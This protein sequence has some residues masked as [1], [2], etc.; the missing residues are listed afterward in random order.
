MSWLT[1]VSAGSPSSKRNLIKEESDDRAVCKVTHSSEVCST[2]SLKTEDK[3]FHCGVSACQERC[4]LP[5]G[6]R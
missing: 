4:L 6:R 1:S 5:L 3:L 2:L